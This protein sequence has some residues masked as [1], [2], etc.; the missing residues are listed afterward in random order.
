MW[1]L[2]IFWVSSEKT[3]A[4]LLARITEA[5]PPKRWGPKGVWGQSPHLKR[6]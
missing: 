1:F 6:G 5:P 3:D 4:D 2:L